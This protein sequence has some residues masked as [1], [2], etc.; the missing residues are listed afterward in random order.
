MVHLL[1]W[2]PFAVALAVPM[3]AENKLLLWP[4]Q[5]A[6][7]FLRNH[8]LSLSFQ[9]LLFVL[10]LELVRVVMVLLQPLLH[11]S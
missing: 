11:S 9:Q 7:L 1:S 2:V 8:K 6:T 10:K 5:L 4:C 3:G